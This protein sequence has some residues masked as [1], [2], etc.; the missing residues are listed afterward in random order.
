MRSGHWLRF[1]LEYTVVGLA[2]AVLVV[3]LFPGQ[4]QEPPTG[5]DPVRVTQAAA[6]DTDRPGNAEV[7]QAPQGEPA[8]GRDGAP[9]TY[10]DAVDTAAPA[11]VNIYTMKRTVE[12]DLP[13]FLDDPFFRRFFGDRPPQR[14]PQTS[15]GSGVIVNED[16]YIITNQHVIE[17]AEEIEVLLADGRD[18]RAKVV[19]GDP[20]T[21]IAVL[22]IDLDNLPVITFG[23]EEHARVGDVVL[24]I[25]N[26]FG[27]G[28]TVTQGIISATGR[29]QLGLS[30]FENFIQTDAAINPGNSGGALVDVDGRL[31]GINTAIFSRT[32]GSHGIGFAIPASIARDVMQ[33]LIE[34]GRVVRGWMG[35]QA[36]SLNEALARSFELEVTEGVV[37]TGVMR[38]GPAEE[39]GL[40]PGDVI[41]EVGERD[42][43]NVQDLLRA[44][45]AQ[46]P[47]SEVTVR[48]Y[49]EGEPLTITLT[50]DE[51]PEQIRQRRP[52]PR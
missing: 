4:P 1:I 38:G 13:P 17:N 6:P 14:R 8:R 7:T 23:R 48:G 47:G 40:R 22:R 33:D 50:V 43:A 45:S 24:A 20:E 41:L 39:A 31:L 44:V 42:I 11:V 3:W 36:Q 2:A 10:A 49:R 29:D 26:P 32:G 34:H 27:V 28:Q 37:I 52:H 46:R 51:R 21:D 9:V 5:P 12:R 35:V 30:T 16:G 19:G 18:A 25:G 15:L